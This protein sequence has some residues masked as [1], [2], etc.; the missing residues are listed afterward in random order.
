MLDTLHQAIDE[1]RQ[2]MKLIEIFKA[3]KRPDASGQMIE[4]KSKDLMQAMTAY[5]PD[6]HEAP[7]VIGHPKD[8]A[9]A[10]AW[11]KR[12]NVEGDILK[13]EFAQVDPNFAEMVEAGRFKKISASFYLADSPHNPKPGYT[14][15]YKNTI[16]NTLLIIVKKMML[17][18][19]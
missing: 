14:L 13:A 10:Y 5:N 11:V 1:Y 16:L 15:S 12:L 7:A 19:H 2:K 6:L 17:V 8:S 18:I 9:P 4:I 3:G